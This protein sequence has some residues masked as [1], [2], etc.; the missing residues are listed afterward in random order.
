MDCEDRNKNSALH[1]AARYGHELIINTLI[2]N[3]ANTAK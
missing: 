2:N 1:I 3:G